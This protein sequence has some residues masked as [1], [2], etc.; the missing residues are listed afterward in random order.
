MQT[1][2]IYILF[3]IAIGIV[4]YCFSGLAAVALGCVL[5]GIMIMLSQL[6]DNQKA[7]ATIIHK[8]GE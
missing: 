5:L 1:L 3:S 4:G 8:M 7:L 2:V 6:A